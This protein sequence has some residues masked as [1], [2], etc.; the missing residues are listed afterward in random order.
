MKQKT[1]SEKGFELDPNSPNYNTAYYE[2][3]VKEFIKEILD[4]IDDCCGKIIKQEEIKE[5]GITKE[6][7][8]DA[9]IRWKNSRLGKKIKQ[10]IKQKA[11]KELVE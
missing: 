4:E 10:I 6:S 11:G 1:L 8:E 5:F 7:Y 3:D 2:E 9:V